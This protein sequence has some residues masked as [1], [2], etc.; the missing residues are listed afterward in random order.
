MHKQ[1][2]L[3][4]II[5][6]VEKIS[7]GTESTSWYLSELIWSGKNFYVVPKPTSIE[8]KGAWHKEKLGKV[9]NRESL[10]WL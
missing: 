1:K 2:M 8:S 9:L 3:Q 4:I 10:L 7:P 6:E 5:S